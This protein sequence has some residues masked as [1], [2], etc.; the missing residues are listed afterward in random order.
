MPVTPL[1][2]KFLARPGAEQLGLA[3]I[4]RNGFH[5]FGGGRKGNVHAWEIE[6]LRSTE[7]ERPLQG[8]R[9]LDLLDLR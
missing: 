3:T 7:I 1:W 9:V 2:T 4:D 5:D 8:T 6:G